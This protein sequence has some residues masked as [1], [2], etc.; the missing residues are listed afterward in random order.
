MATK[1]FSPIHPALIKRM[2]TVKRRAFTLI[3]LL[4][5]IAIIAILAAMLLPALARAKE[6]AKRTQCLSNL[7]QIGLGATLYAGDYQD[8]V[9]PT[10]K[11]MGGTGN[12]FV[13]LALSSPVV[14]AVNT[15][16]RVQNTTG[17]TIWSCPNRPPGLPFYDSADDQWILG[18]SYMGGITNWSYS[19]T[20]YSPVKLA[21]AKSWWV[22]GADL[23]AKVV[24]SG[25]TGQVA[26][27][28]STYYIEYGNVPPHAIKGKPAGGNE[29]FADGSA[30]W[31]KFQTMCRFN[32]YA[33]LVGSTDLWWYQA[34]TDFNAAL[35]A[36]LPTLQTVQ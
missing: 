31:C 20:S 9:P 4:V 5:V 19:T 6:S 3:E 28:G 35:L 14:A 2:N 16:L 10:N 23:N 33:G 29:V 1:P 34:P 13:Q 21:A 11:T 25:W 24:G 18:Y 30:N 8:V 22:L 17:L 7:R 36:Q 26:P 12:N 32:N 15:Y 27:Q